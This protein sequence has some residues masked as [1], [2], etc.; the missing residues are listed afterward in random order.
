MFKSKWK[1]ISTSNN[2]IDPTLVA[3]IETTLIQPFEVVLTSKW[4]VVSTYNLD[5]NLRLVADVVTTLLDIVRT[6]NQRFS[7]TLF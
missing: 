5:I 4:K 7:I 3:D 6:F 1:V 2:D